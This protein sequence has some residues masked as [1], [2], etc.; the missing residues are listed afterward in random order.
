MLTPTVESMNRK[1]VPVVKKKPLQV[2]SPSLHRNRKSL[3]Q[4]S[5]NSLTA[6]VNAFRGE[7]E[8]MG[9]QPCSIP[10]LSLGQD[11]QLSEIP[12]FLII[13]RL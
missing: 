11:P 6:R 1:M 10:F 4:R 13:H 12:K 8:V 7:R 2:S 9:T 5:V 3:P